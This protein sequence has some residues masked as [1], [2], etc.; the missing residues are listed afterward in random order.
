MD[1]VAKV[2]AFYATQKWL[3]MSGHNSKMREQLASDCF[4]FF[5]SCQ[6]ARLSRGEERSLDSSLLN[7]TTHPRTSESLGRIW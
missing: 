5:M 3:A 2:L 7:L 1:D 6:P 4:V